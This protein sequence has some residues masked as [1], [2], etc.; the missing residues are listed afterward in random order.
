MLSWCVCTNRSSTLTYP[1][2]EVEG[3]LHALEAV[4]AALHDVL[5]GEVLGPEDVDEDR[6]PP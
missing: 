2:D 5:R 3:A 1:Q 4:E 6:V